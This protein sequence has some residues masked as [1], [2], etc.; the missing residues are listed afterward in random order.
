MTSNARPA[1]VM[2]PNLISP[3]SIFTI[4]YSGVSNI[5]RVVLSKLSGVTH[6][7]HMDARQL[8]LD[9]A[10]AAST[11]LAGN[12][13]CQAPPDFTVSPLVPTYFSSSAM[14]F[15]QRAR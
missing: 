10:S 8:V 5:D 9:C 13:T 11:R 15:L 7:V 14:T 2:A 3:A 12:T 6:S 4:Q 1:I